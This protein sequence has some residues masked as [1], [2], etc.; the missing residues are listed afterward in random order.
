MELND[1]SSSNYYSVNVSSL[2]FKNSAEKP[3]MGI[4]EWKF[5]TVE[6]LRKCIGLENVL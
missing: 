3:N 5:Q 2:H 1:K 4:H 6:H